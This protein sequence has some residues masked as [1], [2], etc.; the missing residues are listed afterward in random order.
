MQSPGIV[1]ALDVG[2]A[3]SA[4][5]V[6]GGVDA[7]MD[8][9]DLERVE[10]AL[11]RRVAETVALPA[12]RRRDP[13]GGKDLAVGVRGIPGGLNRSSQRFSNGG[14]DGGTEARRGTSPGVGRC[15][16]MAISS[17]SRAM[18]ACRVSRP[19]QPATLRVCMSIN[20]AR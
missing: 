20:A 7:V 6:A 3:V 9:L 13:C 12:H 15:R 1:E 11:H 16:L 10:E 4:R 8:A 17:A 14:C 5:V 19:A 18:S 2:E